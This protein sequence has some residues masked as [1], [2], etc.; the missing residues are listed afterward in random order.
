MTT[1]LL[2][3]W[4]NSGDVLSVL[5][6]IGSDIIQK[7][8]AQLVGHRLRLPGMKNRGLYI[9][10]VALSFG[11]VAYAFSNMIG[12]VGDMKLM[13]ASDRSSI[14]VNCA[15]GFVREN[16]SWIL[17]RL[18]RDHEIRCEADKRSK[19]EDNRSRSIRIDI[20]QLGPAAGPSR[21]IV[22][23]VGWV[24][25]LVQLGMA[26]VP[27]ASYGDW[28]I[29]MVTL[30]GNLLVA[31]T[32]ALPQ[33]REEKWPGPKLAREAVFCLTRGNG[34]GYIMVFIGARG[35]W[36][37][38]RLATGSLPP[39]PETRWV[40]LIL[41]ALWTCL[42]MSLPGLKGNTWYLVVIRGVGMIHNVIAAGAARKPGASDVHI[43]ELTR[44]PI[45]LGK[46][47]VYSDDPNAD[48]DLEEKFEE[49]SDIFNWSSQEEKPIASD[50]GSA[51]TI[52][53]LSMP[54]WLYS[55][56]RED[57]VPEWLEPIKNTPLNLPKAETYIKSKYGP[58]RLDNHD[59]GLHVVFAIGVHGALIELEKWVPTA[60][61][62]MV[63]IFFPGGL[64]YNDQAIRDNV[65]KKFWRSAY[66]TKSIR[67]RAEE[68]RRTEPINIVRTG[69]TN[70]WKVDGKH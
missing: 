3:R 6:L 18:L 36:D 1:G 16:K 7:A 9:A 65:H 57:G 11:W 64:R 15:N 49:L 12:V 59:R 38:E 26:A 23:W 43:T 4:A 5:L 48:V 39:R 35:S 58:R 56:S 25:I 53:R 10:P 62:A 60:G 46:H 54:R 32:C 69:I 40:S 67:K 29:F 22:W 42:L 61:L 20:F 30:C 41:A 21:D 14:L 17:C 2:G 44:A 55:M 52:A 47:E 50:N 66:H 27:W 70:D 37:L 34:H 8:I 68:R 63:Q 24:V 19:I 33:W 28:S 45:I 13:P 51:T 31:A